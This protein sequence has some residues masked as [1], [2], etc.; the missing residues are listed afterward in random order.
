M[1]R[2]WLYVD[3]CL[4]TGEPAA[5]PDLKKQLQERFEMTDMGLCEFVIGLRI[6]QDFE[7]RTVKLSQNEYIDDVLERFDMA[8][9]NPVSRL[10]RLVA[11]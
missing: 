3:D 2:L 4:P 11:D 6:E 7:N 5:S 8:A 10:K 9:C 1:E